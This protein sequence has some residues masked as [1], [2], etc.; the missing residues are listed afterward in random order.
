MS[1]VVTEISNTR[2]DFLKIVSNKVQWVHP[3]GDF[4]PPTYASAVGH[5][6]IAFTVTTTDESTTLNIADFTV[7]LTNT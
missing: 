4:T 6:G 5:F 2:S 7:T 1:A 3:A